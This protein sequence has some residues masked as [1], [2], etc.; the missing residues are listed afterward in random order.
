MT[1]PEETL[2]EL[3]VWWRGVAKDERDAAKCFRSQTYAASAKQCEVRALVWDRCAQ[4][5]EL[6]L[7]G[8][9]FNPD[10]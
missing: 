10:V 7:A 2:R 8:K 9:L 5:L 4:Q 1:P 3:A 6:V